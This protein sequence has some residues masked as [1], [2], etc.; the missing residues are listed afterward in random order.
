MKKKHRVAE[1]KKPVSKPAPKPT[2]KP[3][4][5]KED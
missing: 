5:A 2:S 4:K 1:E 3:K